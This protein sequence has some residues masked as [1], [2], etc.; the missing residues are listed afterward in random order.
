M[1]RTIWLA[2]LSEYRYEI[3]KVNHVILR[4]E[5]YQQEYSENETPE[6]PGSNFVPD[7][8]YQIFRLSFS[9][10]QRTAGYMAYAVSVEG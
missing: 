2:V 8:L 9:F 1:D 3:I 6:T 7:E 4:L 5:I 10:T